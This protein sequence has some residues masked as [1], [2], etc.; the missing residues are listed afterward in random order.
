MLKELHFEE[1]SVRFESHRL[2]WNLIGSFGGYLNGRGSSEDCLKDLLKNMFKG[3]SF[4]K[5]FNKLQLARW[6]ISFDINLIYELVSDCVTVY[7]I[8][9]INFLP[10][11]SATRESSRHRWLSVIRHPKPSG[12]SNRTNRLGRHCSVSMCFKQKKINLSVRLKSDLFE[13]ALISHPYLLS[14]TTFIYYRLWYFPP[15]SSDKTSKKF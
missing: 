14:S 15:D 5:A 2:A 12:L 1:S 9:A 3:K 10:T 6:D 7:A 11:F 4:P 8:R 13:D